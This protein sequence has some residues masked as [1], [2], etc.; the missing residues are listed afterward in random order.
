M[1]KVLKGVGG[2]AEKKGAKNT[3][4]GKVMLQ[5]GKKKK[6]SFPDKQ[7]LKESVT[8]GPALEEMLKGV[9]HTEIK[10]TD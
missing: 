1:F 8:T 4:S 6:K 2:G 7:K 3:L 9:L 5:K 10:D